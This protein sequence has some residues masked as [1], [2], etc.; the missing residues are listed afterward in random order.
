M[1]KVRTETKGLDLNLG[2]RV[3]RP[4]ER[5]GGSADQ[6]LIALNPEIQADFEETIFSLIENEEARREG[7]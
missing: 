1:S 3:K 5:I 2:Y 6:V 7:K 4:D